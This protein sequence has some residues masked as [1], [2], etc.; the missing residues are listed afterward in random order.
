MKSSAQQG[1]RQMERIW[2]SDWV[3]QQRLSAC[4]IEAGLVSVAQSGVRK[5]AAAVGD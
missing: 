5:P 2:T 3:V 1:R 4:L